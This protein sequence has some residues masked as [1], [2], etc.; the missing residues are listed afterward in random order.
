[1]KKIIRLTESDLNNIVLKIISE[2]ANVD[3][4]DRIYDEVD[5]SE[6]KYFEPLTPEE[7]KLAN[8]SEV[9]EQRRPNT[10]KRRKIKRNYC[11]SAGFLGKL[12]SKWHGRTK[13]NR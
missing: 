4:C 11:K 10:S 5:P 1:M 9:A 6:E 7:E 12:R 3:A 2:E 13:R 8:D